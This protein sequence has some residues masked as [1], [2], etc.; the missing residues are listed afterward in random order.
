MTE[1]QNCNKKLREQIKEEM[2]KI[3]QIEHNIDQ[4]S[5]KSQL[6]QEQVS[7]SETKSALLHHKIEYCQEFLQ[8]LAEN[9]LVLL[10][11]QETTENI[12]SL[13]SMCTESSEKKQ[14]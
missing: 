12:E 11:E 3:S 8:A 6:V 9:K 5:V 14:A 4:T 13:I 10:H 1:T 2:L 7:H